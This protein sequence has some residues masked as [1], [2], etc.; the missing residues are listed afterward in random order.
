MHLIGP[1]PSPPGSAVHCGMGGYIKRRSGHPG[2]L[3]LCRRSGFHIRRV[4]R[5]QTRDGKAI[6]RPSSLLQLDN[7]S[8]IKMSIGHCNYFMAKN[9]KNVNEK[10]GI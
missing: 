3:V 5:Q 2:P 1:L 9:V 6:N 10:P 4:Q 8:F 7:V